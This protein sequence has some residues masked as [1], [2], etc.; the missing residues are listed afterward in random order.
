MMK[1]VVCGNSVEDVQNGVEA[2]KLAIASG[3]SCGVGGSTMEE[4][5][6]NLEAMK[7]MVGGIAPPSCSCPCFCS[8]C[9][10]EDE[11]EDEEDYEEG[12][13]ALAGD[14]GE[15]SSLHNNPEDAMVDAIEDGYDL[16]EIGIYKVQVYEDGCVVVIDTIYHPN[17]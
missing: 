9:E 6:K 2:M 10:N 8:C 3:A 15:L 16:E 17:K 12:Y 13:M 5:E 14:G 4:V 11:A 1:Y 7:Q